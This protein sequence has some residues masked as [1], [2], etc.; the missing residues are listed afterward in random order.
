MP[1]RSGTTVTGRGDGDSVGGGASVTS[2]STGFVASFGFST[3]CASTWWMPAVEGLG[4]SKDA[5]AVP[6]AGLTRELLSAVPSHKNATVPGAPTRRRFSAVRFGDASGR[7]ALG[8]SFVTG[9]GGG[10]GGVGWGGS[11]ETPSAVPEV[12]PTKPEALATKDVP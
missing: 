9:G 4:T 8:A 12:H 10:G 6:S 1:T 2:K 7:R 11:G 3:H 5:V